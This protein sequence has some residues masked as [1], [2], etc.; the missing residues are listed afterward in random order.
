MGLAAGWLLRNALGSLGVLVVVGA[1]AFGLP[2][3]DGAVAAG[4]PVSNDVPYR[5]GG[6]ITVV[7]PPGAV[8]DVTGTRPRGDRGTAVFR[9]GE[10]RYVLVVTPYAGDVAGAEARLRT[11][12]C[13]TGR[14]RA[15]GPTTLLGQDWRT[16]WR[17]GAIEAPEP[18]G[19]RYAVRVLTQRLV[20]VVVT[21]PAGAVAERLPAIEASLATIRADATGGGARGGAR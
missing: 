6:G 20:E 18:R 15:A 16:G 8:L 11:K 7:P 13:G 9:L 12:L 1:M 21:G 3:L 14:C 10:V 2:A 19:G 17:T 5:L 4:R